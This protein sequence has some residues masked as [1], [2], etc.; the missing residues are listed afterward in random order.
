MNVFKTNH[1]IPAKAQGFP[2]ARVR[3]AEAHAVFLHHVNKGVLPSVLGCSSLPQAPP[4]SKAGFSSSLRTMPCFSL[5]PSPESTFENGDEASKYS[6]DVHGT[7][8]E[9][10]HREIT[11]TRAFTLWENG[12]CD[13]K[14]MIYVKLQLSNNN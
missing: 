13:L 12:G 11:G 1:L 10:R 14:P 6:W 2:T 8:R 7:D 4:Q 9:Q 5:S 3:P